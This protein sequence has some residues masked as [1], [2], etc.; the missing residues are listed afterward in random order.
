MQ[1]LDKSTPPSNLHQLTQEQ[2]GAWEIFHYT[3][4]IGVLLVLTQRCFHEEKKPKIKMSQLKRVPCSSG[5]Y[6][7]AEV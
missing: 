1:Q 6:T 3:V 4:I 5:I 7:A 2:Q